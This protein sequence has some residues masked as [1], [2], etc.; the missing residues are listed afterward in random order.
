MKPQTG[1]QAIAIRLRDLFEQACD[2]RT[3]RIP[4]LCPVSQAQA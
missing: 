4:A 2:R 3:I 1:W